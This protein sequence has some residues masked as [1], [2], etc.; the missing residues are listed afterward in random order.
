MSSSVRSLLAS[1]PAVTINLSALDLFVVGT[2]NRL[3]RKSA[4]D[5][6]LVTGWTSWRL[7]PPDKGG[8][9]RCSL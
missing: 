6:A 1:G 8:E 2:D 5:G 3:Y 4:T 9:P 7:L